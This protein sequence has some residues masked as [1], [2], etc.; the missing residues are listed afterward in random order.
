MSS[1]KCASPQ[2]RIHFSP[3]FQSHHE[4][5]NHSVNRTDVD[6][7]FSPVLVDKLCTDPS[8]TKIDIIDMGPG[9]ARNLEN[10]NGPMGG[11]HPNDRGHAMIAAE[12]I[13]RILTIIDSSK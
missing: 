4:N 10:K 1:N 5:R 8:A 9:L 12:L 11:L 6:I 3:P 2:Q 7:T 13:P